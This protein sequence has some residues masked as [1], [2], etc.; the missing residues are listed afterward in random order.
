VY[1]EANHGVILFN[2]QAKILNITWSSIKRWDSFKQLNN[3]LIS[4]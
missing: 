3:R 2:E 1:T 4:N